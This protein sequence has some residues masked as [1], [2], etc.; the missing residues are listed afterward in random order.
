MSRPSKNLKNHKNK[1]SKTFK[2][3]YHGKNCKN[4]LENR[5]FKTFK[6]I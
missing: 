5:M 3:L 1:V 2:N 6:T 4:F